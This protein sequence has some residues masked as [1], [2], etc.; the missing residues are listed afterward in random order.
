VRHAAYRGANK[1][2]VERTLNNSRSLLMISAQ[3]LA[4][5]ADQLGLQADKAVDLS[6]AQSLR[7]RASEWKA[8]AAE[9]HVIENDPLYR[10]IHDRQ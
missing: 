10:Q 2:D 8:L 3:Q 9:L 7:R 6:Y 1:L 5:K 4:A